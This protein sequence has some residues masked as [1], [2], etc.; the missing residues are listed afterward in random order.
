MFKSLQPSYTAVIIGASGGIGRAV[1]DAIKVDPHCEKI[2]GLSRSST[3]A[4]DYDTP[5][6]LE[7]AATQISTE[8]SSIDLLIIATGALTAP[9]GTPPE[10]SVSQLTVEAMEEIFRINTIGP[11]IAL[12]AFTPLLARDRRTLT[13]TLSARVGSIGDNA[14][15]GWF[16]YRASKAALN[17]ITHSAAIEQ[18]RRNDQSVCVA[19]HPGTI[20]TGLSKP[21]ARNRFTHSAEACASN[22]I[23]V[24]DTRTPEHSG[25]FFDYAGKE[26]CW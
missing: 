21:Y 15:G 7:E 6:S 10:K 2:F 3:P 5:Q 26:I 20:E 4:I 1:F 11:A 22:L 13:A 12:R 9:N 23:Q 17:Q 25:G 18:S 8:I 19:L 16:S 14:L 24:L